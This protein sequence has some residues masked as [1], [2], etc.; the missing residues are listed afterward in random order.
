MLKG[1]FKTKNGEPVSAITLAESVKVTLE[2][3][4]YSLADVLSI[5]AQDPI[6]SVD[7]GRDADIAAG[8]EYTVPQYVVGCSNISVYLDGLKVSCGTGGGFVEVGTTNTVSTAI[9]FNSAVPKEVEIIV[10]VGR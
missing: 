2:K 9:K 8:T 4:E 10:R 6:E 1:T 3:G 5:L 7:A